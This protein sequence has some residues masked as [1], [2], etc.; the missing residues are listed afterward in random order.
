MLPVNYR[1]DP[2]LPPDLEAKRAASIEA[3]GTRWLLHPCHAPR[4]GHYSVDGWPRPAKKKG[5]A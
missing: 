4:K 3:L 5:K 2:A 1:P